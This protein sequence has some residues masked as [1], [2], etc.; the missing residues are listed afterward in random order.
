M[1]QNMHSSRHMSEPA[2]TR[3]PGLDALIADL[4]IHCCNTN[5]IVYIN[6][7]KAKEPWVLMRKPYNAE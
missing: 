3:N 1:L 2:Y 4:R 6:I 5:T 7:Q